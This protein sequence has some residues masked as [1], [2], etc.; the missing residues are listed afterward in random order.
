MIDIITV[1]Y[2][3]HEELK[4]LIPTLERY[5]KD[6]RL[7]I[8]DNASKDT[9]YLKTLEDKAQVIYNDKNLGYAAG[10]NIGMRATENPYAVFVNPDCRMTAGWLEGL[11]GVL[12]SDDKIVATGPLLYDDKANQYAGNPTYVPLSLTVNMEINWVSGAVFCVKRSAWEEIGEFLEEYFFMWEETDWCQI[13]VD[14]GYKIRQAADSTVIH[15][16]GESCKLDTDFFKKHFAFGRKLFYGRHKQTD[17]KRVLIM[18]PSYGDINA[19]FH[20][21]YMNL[22]V[23]LMKL[24]FTEKEYEFFPAT[25]CNQFVYDARNGAVEMA[26]SAGCDYILYIDSDQIVPPDTFERLVAHDKE[27]VSALFFKRV[28][29]YLPLMFQIEDTDD[30]GRCKYGAMRDWPE[31]ELVKVDAIGGGCFLVKT[32]VFDDMPK[33]YFYVLDDEGRQTG[34][35]IFFSQRL[36][37]MGIPMYVDTAAPVGHVGEIVVGE[38]TYR[39]YAEQLKEYK[40]SI[41]GKEEE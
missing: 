1:N 2:N 15:V 9:T 29:P 22:I 33:P 39:G 16:G 7:T 4:K 25:I 20:V 36:M 10:V 37:K 28:A 24:Q 23:R 18:T 30:V 31:G 12:K 6:Y 38:A 34:E 13:A 5:T 14:K 35:D 11:V 3:S 32:S 41:V 40:E 8:V 27:C 21:N 17:K 26:I 19:Q